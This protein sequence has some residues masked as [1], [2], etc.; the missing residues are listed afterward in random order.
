MVGIG[1]GRPEVARASPTSR[2]RVAYAH[3]TAFTSEPLEAYAEALA[4]LLPMDDARIY[5]VRAAA[6]RSRRR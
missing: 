3:G 1:H 2:P 4:S 6:R 5:P